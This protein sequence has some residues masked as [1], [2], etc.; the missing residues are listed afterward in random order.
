MVDKISGEETPMPNWEDLQKVW[1]DTP[2][3]DMSK[4]AR[5]AKFVWW[6]MRV[7]FALEIVISF[8][9]LA[10]FASLFEVGEPSSMAFSIFGIFFCIAA[11]WVA[12]K[13]RTGAW[14]EPEDTALSLV[15]LHIERAKSAVRYIKLNIYLGFAAAAL[16]PLGFWT[17]YD[18][19]D[20]VSADRLNLAIGVFVVSFLA[21]IL[22]P[23]V[24]RPY[25]RK[26]RALIK[27]LQAIAEQ[28]RGA[29]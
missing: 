4:L 17:L 11:I 23:I 9:G 24:T 14:G 21:I 18:N 3:V 19:Y 16:I 13:I 10:I 25:V 1:Q 7:N 2:P 5:Q 20:T 8:I 29:D 27:S 15:E 28:L 22:F 6:R 12:V 26:K